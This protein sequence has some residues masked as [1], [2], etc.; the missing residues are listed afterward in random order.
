M[1]AWHWPVRGYPHRAP[2]L[3][4][5]E[6]GRRDVS[7]TSPCQ[8]TQNWMLVLSSH[9]HASAVSRLL[10]LARWFL[11]AH[12]IFVPPGNEITRVGGE[13]SQ[14]MGNLNKIWT[15]LIANL[16]YYE[17][18][19]AAAQTKINVLPTI[20]SINLS[21]NSTRATSFFF[22]SFLLGSFHPLNGKL[23]ILDHHIP[24]NNFSDYGSGTG[25]H[26]QETNRKSQPVN[27][28]LTLSNCV[29]YFF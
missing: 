10:A 1:A 20:V 25:I 13:I 22:F 18:H 8:E 6:D 16:C 17:I 3:V 5:T 28:A 15:P 14:V 23:D 7:A 26:V 19:Y 12:Q 2:A 21:I 4:S 29:I 9:L 27:L 11:P 24:R